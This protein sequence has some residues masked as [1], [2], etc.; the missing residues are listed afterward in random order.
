MNDTTHTHAHTHTHT[1]SGTHHHKKCNEAQQA[2]VARDLLTRQSA[3]L[4][5]GSLALDAGTYP[6]ATRKRIKPYGGWGDIRD[7]QLCT[8]FAQNGT[9]LDVKLPT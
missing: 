3:N 4:F 2:A 9:L 6:P 8:S 7:H 5:P 1:H